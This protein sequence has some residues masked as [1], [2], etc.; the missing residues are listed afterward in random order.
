[1]LEIRSH[2]RLVLGA[3]FSLAPFLKAQPICSPHV[4]F[5]IPNTTLRVPIS[6]HTSHGVKSMRLVIPKTSKINKCPRLLGVPFG[7][8]IL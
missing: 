7:P 8:E 1:M 4:P 6:F 2:P 3:V 5:D